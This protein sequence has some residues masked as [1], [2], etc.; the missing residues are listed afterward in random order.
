MVRRIGNWRGHVGATAMHDRH[1]SKPA[2]RL[3]LAAFLLWPML[4]L[5]ANAGEVTLRMKGGD[6]EVTGELMSFNGLKYTITA[7][8]FGTMTFEASRFEC[9]GADCTRLSVAPALPPER[10]DASSPGAF[11]VRGSSL[12]GSGLMPALIRGYAASLGA[13]MTQI[14]GTSPGETKF[15]LGDPGG[16]ELAT[17]VVQ[18]EPASA[19]FAALQQSADTIAISDRPI[20]EQE[21]ASMGEAAARIRTPDFEHVLAD[22][23]LAVV[24]SPDNGAVSLSLD[25]IAKVFAGKITDWFDLG[26]SGGKITIYAMAPTSELQNIF[27][28]LIM[29]PRG[30][31]LADQIRIVETEGDVAD[32]VARDANGIGVTSL[33]FLR[34]AK[35][36]NIVGSCGLITKPSPFTVKSGEYPLRRRL[37]VYSAK[38]LEQPAARGLLRYALSNESQADISANQFVDR[39]VEAL[40]LDDQKWRMANAVNAPAQIFDAEQMRNLLTDV[41]GARRLSL[42]FRYVVGTPDLDMP[43]RENLTR[44]SALLQRPEYGGKK[45]LLIGFTDAS[46]RLQAN[47]A[48]SHKRAQQ[49]RTAVLA[50]SGGHVNVAGIEVRGYGPLA[51]VACSETEEGVRLNRRVEVWIHD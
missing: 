11:T 24:V 34:N 6:L 37:Y 7:P 10:L 12:I 5:A 38:T 8:A 16:A 22:D 36:L 2:M 9:V 42:T 45:V 48:T 32:A 17:I 30:L 15:R 23:A 20:A 31:A 40:S 44:L 49:I 27:T 19:A 14:V 1:S 26:V 4:A 39:G 3:A 41:K 25:S 46:G 18:K 29:K 51:P 28:N 21:A 13:T 43:S 33:A 50:G 35:P 47:M